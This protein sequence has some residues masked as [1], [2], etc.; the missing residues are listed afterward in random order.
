[1]ILLPLVFPGQ[2]IHYKIGSICNPS[3]ENIRGWVVSTTFV[4]GKLNTGGEE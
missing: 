1:M 4:A 2:D 3:I